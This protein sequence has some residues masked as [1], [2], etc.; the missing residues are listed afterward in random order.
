MYF[1]VVKNFITCKYNQ[2]KALII[3]HQ[4]YHH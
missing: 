2:I 1:Y 3:C 4:I